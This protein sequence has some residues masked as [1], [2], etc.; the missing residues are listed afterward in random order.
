[1]PTAPDTRWF[2][3]VFSAD[4]PESVIDSVLDGIPR[5]HDS[6]RGGSK[7][8]GLGFDLRESR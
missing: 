7:D 1:M 4:L 2:F 3:C 6:I 5:G 8:G